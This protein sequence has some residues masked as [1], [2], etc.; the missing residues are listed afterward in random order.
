MGGGGGIF[1]MIVFD[2]EVD[3]EDDEV[4]VECNWRRP[5]FDAIMTLINKS[6]I[7]VI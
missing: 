6:K 7:Y 3:E 5:L 1:R 4:Y 2:D